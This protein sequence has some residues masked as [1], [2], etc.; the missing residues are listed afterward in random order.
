MLRSF[1]EEAITQLA[2]V[3]RSRLVGTGVGAVALFALLV[4]PLSPLARADSSNLLP[5]GSFQSGTSS[6]TTSNAA[7]TI[8]PDGSSDTYAGRLALNTIATTYQLSANPRPVLNSGAGLV[9]AANGL[10][11]SDTPG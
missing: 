9:Y 3:K 7:L 4:L 8:A 1:G 5:N 10:V 6:W 11:R 2:K